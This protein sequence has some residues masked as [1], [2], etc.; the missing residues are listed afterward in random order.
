MNN[1]LILMILFSTLVS[2]VFAFLAKYGARERI[3]YFFFLLGSFVVVSIVAS[4]LMFPF[5]F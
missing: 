5:P 2:L 3:K 1:H 4:W